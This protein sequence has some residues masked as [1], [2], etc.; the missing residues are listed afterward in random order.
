LQAEAESRRKKQRTEDREEQRK[1]ALARE[2]KNM[3]GVNL[4]PAWTPRYHFTIKK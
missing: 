3:E 1:R 4:G 2:L